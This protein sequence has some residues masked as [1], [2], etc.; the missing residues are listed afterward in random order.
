MT[1]SGDVTNALLKDADTGLMNAF[2]EGS[3][4]LQYFESLVVSDM[5]AREPLEEYVA[6]PPS[7]RDRG[8]LTCL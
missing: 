6:P 7:R 3:E 5:P 8:K 4:Y 1:E 2:K